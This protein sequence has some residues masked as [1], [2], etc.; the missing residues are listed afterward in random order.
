MR[1]E[2]DWRII[3]SAV[4]RVR[5]WGPSARMALSRRVINFRFPSFS[6]PVEAPL[7]FI[8]ERW[9]QARRCEHLT[10]LWT[11]VK[12]ET[13]KVNRYLCSFPWKR[14]SLCFDSPDTPF[15]WT[16]QSRSQ[17]SPGTALSPVNQQKLG[18][19]A[20]TGT[21]RKNAMQRPGNAELEPWQ[22]SLLLP[23]VL[24]LRECSPSFSLASSLV[25]SSPGHGGG[26]CRQYG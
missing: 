3:K 14:W 4:V 9:L 7:S 1:G 21:A 13:T 11:R 20:K 17:S 16:N 6:F 18:C 26:F 2:C 12:G 5:P 25:V 24:V 15:P 10:P 23:V 8:L 19:E 22:T